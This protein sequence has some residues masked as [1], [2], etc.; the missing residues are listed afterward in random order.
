MATYNLRTRPV[1]AITY[2]TE[3]DMKTKKQLELVKTRVDNLSVMYSRIEHILQ[4][5]VILLVCIVLKEIYFMFSPK[6]SVSGFV[7][8]LN[9]AIY[10]KCDFDMEK[11]NTFLS[12]QMGNILQKCVDLYNKVKTYIK[13]IIDIYS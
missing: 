13:N 5:I 9:W 12:I 2:K 10:K 8:K 11:V 6:F 4:L 3:I 7:T 1:S